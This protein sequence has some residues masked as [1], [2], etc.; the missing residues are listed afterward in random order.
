MPVGQARS[1][2]DQDAA[3]HAQ[4]S[5]EAGTSLR[6][7]AS[8]AWQKGNEGEARPYVDSDESCSDANT[9]STLPREL[10]TW[11]DS[12]RPDSLQQPTISTHEETEGDNDQEPFVLDEQLDRQ[13]RLSQQKE[14]AEAARVAAIALA[15]QL[16]DEAEQ[17]IVDSISPPV[18][19]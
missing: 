18:S 15:Q 6:A 4:R 5:V 13:L 9:S 1:W 3:L 11:S 10:S 16:T 19:N 12:L 2:S 8:D 17:R 7:T 14:A